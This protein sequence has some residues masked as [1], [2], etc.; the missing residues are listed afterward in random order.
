MALTGPGPASRDGEFGVCALPGGQRG[1]KLCFRPGDLGAN[2]RFDETIWGKSFFLQ[3][4]LVA[5][6][7]IGRLLT[8]PLGI[9][10]NLTSDARRGTSFALS[11]WLGAERRSRADVG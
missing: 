10:I 8:L 11:E 4:N 6:R 9:G 1:G 2:C 7:L 5:N 3:D